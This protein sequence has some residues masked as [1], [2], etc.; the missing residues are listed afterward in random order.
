[1]NRIRLLAVLRALQLAEVFE[2][3]GKR[4]RLSR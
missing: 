2:A 4:A 1:L 3:I